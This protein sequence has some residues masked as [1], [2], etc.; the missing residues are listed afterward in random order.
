MK[1]AWKVGLS[2]GAAILMIA[3]AY[4]AIFGATYYDVYYANGEEAPCLYDCSSLYTGI[5]VVLLGYP[6]WN[7]PSWRNVN[8]SGAGC[9]PSTMTTYTPQNPPPSCLYPPADISTDYTKNYAGVF[10]I[11]LGA[12]AAVAVV[13]GGE[14]KPETRPSTVN[15]TEPGSERNI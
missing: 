9:V 10:L 5:T 1:T 14:P 11:I 2:I 3:G 13:M 15:L 6:I 8:Y 12:V 4:F 7:P